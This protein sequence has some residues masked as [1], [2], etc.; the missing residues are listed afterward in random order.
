MTQGQITATSRVGVAGNAFATLRAC[1]GLL[2]KFHVI[3]GVSRLEL[4]CRQLWDDFS[5]LPGHSIDWLLKAP[6]FPD[7]DRAF[8][9]CC[10]R[11]D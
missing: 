2:T 5:G 9:F 11:S 7:E 8:R 3:Q 1:S 10:C 6:I 4:D